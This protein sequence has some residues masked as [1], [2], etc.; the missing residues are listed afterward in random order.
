M[1]RAEGA[2]EA[3]NVGPAYAPWFRAG[4][5]G[6]AIGEVFAPA[7]NMLRSIEGCDCVC[8]FGTGG[9]VG[10]CAPSLEKTALSARVGSGTSGGLLG[11]TPAEFCWLF[12]ACAR[13]PLGRRWLCFPLL[14]CCT[15]P[16]VLC[17]GCCLPRGARGIA[18]PC[19]VDMLGRCDC[20]GGFGDGSVASSMAVD[21]TF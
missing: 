1:G 20:Y 6:I 3:W 7:E 13:F 11:D 5:A 15:S 18:I 4:V 9:P 14:L 12:P 19:A 2:G 21:G 17:V 8:F 16:F 10:G